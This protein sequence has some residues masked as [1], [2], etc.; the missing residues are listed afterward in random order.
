MFAEEGKG[1][2]TVRQN[3]LG[4]MQQGGYPSPYDR[5]IAT[6]MT[7]KSVNWL[8]DKLNKC[9]TDD[10]KVMT[11][12][13]ASATLLGIRGRVTKFQPVEEVKKETDFELRLPKGTQWWMKLRSLLKILAKHDSTYEAEVTR[14]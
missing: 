7:A 9:S 1:K 12:D 8:N 4:H 14:L 13:P 6:K 10:G 3:V 5:S 11:K 2:F